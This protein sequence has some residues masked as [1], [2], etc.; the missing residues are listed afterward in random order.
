MV[1]VYVKKKVAVEV[2]VLSHG[3][4]LCNGHHRMKETMATALRTRTGI[5]YPTA[6]TYQYPE[7]ELS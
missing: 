3:K 5:E 4:Y 2:V 6:M 7:V 1:S